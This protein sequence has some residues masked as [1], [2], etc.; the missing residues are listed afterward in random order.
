ME[1]RLKKVRVGSGFYVDAICTLAIAALAFCAALFVSH[2]NA[3]A[4]TDGWEQWGTCEWQIDDEGTLTIRSVDN[5]GEGE[6]GNLDDGSAAPWNA[7]ASE[8]KTVDISSYVSAGDSLQGLFEG[9]SNLTEIKGL[10]NLD[11]SSV[12]NMSGL[13]SGCSS[14]EAIDLS[15][16]DATYVTDMSSMFA[17]CSNLESIDLSLFN[18]DSLY[19]ASNMFANCTNLTSIDLSVFPTYNIKDFSGMFR[20]CSSLS[21]IIV[22]DFDFVGENCETMAGMFEGCTSLTHLPD[23]FSL[24]YN[25]NNIDTTGMFLNTG[26]ETLDTFYAGNNEDVIN[27]DWSGDNR[28]FYA[29]TPGWNRWGNAEWVIDESGCL[30]I[31][32]R[33]NAESGDLE[34]ADYSQP[35]AS[36]RSQIRSVSITKPIRVYSHISY[37]FQGCSNL[38]TVEGLK[39]F[40][41]IE[42]LNGLFANCSSLKS[43]A[44]NE[45][46][47]SSLTGL[48]SMFSGC[49]SLESIDLSNMDLSEAT[50]MMSVFDG[51]T[52]LK[53]VNLTGINTQNATDMS[54]M[55]NDCQSLASIDLTDFDTQSVVN[56]QGMFYNCSSLKELD[57][58]SLNLSNTTDLSSLVSD[59]TSLE[60]ITLPEGTIYAGDLTSMF[61]NCEALTELNMSDTY[62]KNIEN[63]PSMFSGCTGLKT[64]DL[65]NFDT[66]RAIDMSHMFTDCSSLASLAIPDNFIGDKCQSIDGMFSGCVSLQNLPDNFSFGPNAEKLTANGGIFY[67]NQPLTRAV[68]LLVTYYNGSDETVLNYNWEGDNRR[69]VTPAGDIAGTVTIS[70]NPC[71]GVALKATV[72][73][74]DSC[75]DAQLLYQ[76]FDAADGS[77]VSDPTDSA[78]FAIPQ[79][80]EGKSFYCVVTDGSGTYGS[81]LKSDAITASHTFGKWVITTEPTCVDEGEETRTC[82]KCGATETRTIP[83]KGHSPI[84]AWSSD[85]SG[86]W[87]ACANCDEH[88]DAAEH[89]FGEWAEKDAATCTEGGTEARTC[90]TCGYEETRSTDPAGHS[91][92]EWSVTTPA[93]CTAEGV[94]SRTC[95]KCGAT[96]TRAIDATGHTFGEWVTTTEPTCTEE[97]EETRTCENCDAFET[98]PVAAK[99]HTAGEAWESNATDHW[100][101]CTE[102][103]VELDSEAHKFGEWTTTVEPTEDV[104]GEREHTCEVCGHVETAEVPATGH[105]ADGA[106]HSDESG[107]WHVCTGCGEEIEKSAHEYGEWTTTLEPTCTEEGTKTRACTVCGYEQTETISENGHS[108][109]E[110]E[111]T[112]EPTCVDE[113]E[114]TRTCANCDAT[115][116]RPVP[117]TGEHVY[118]GWTSDESGHRHICETCGLVTDDAAHDFGEWVVTKDVTC[119]EDGVETRTCATCGYEETR[120]V[121]APGHEPATEWSSDASEHWHACAN[122]DEHL[123]A[124]AHEFGAWT[125]TTE[126][127]CTE[128]GSQTRTCA[129]CDYTEAAVIPAAGHS[130][131]DWEIISD[132]TET[133]DGSKKHVCEAC[134]FE[135]TVTIPATGGQQ[136]S[137]DDN[138][139]DSDQQ[140]G[141]TDDAQNG[142]GNASDAST[143]DDKGNALAQ[144]GD[145]TPVA[146]LAFGI[147]ATLAVA[148][149]A[150]RKLRA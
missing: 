134:G 126:A 100:H 32:P 96:E 48:T 148:G 127:T 78:E 16:L 142:N 43:V 109:G 115:E 122:C 102:C 54:Y 37:L 25:A 111:V 39:N 138:K 120:P 143:N 124:A 46:D 52:S 77:A 73:L 38:E 8:V 49:S 107:H 57:F 68:N 139:G 41:N 131:G 45:I 27:Y 105:T 128:D 21:S 9:C 29:A 75:A 110:W 118:A 85:E 20:G 108:F 106:W 70:G 99:G 67:V 44:I 132:A 80:S 90:A 22:S 133:Q 116:T 11:T 150:M 69:L 135:E 137:Q 1:Q 34:N 136:G 3:Y 42:S 10:G 2:Q 7:R 55:F 84:D 51:C 50:W 141:Q 121:A 60:K 94:E 129:T 17:S 24:G 83:A 145:S 33:F 87:H 114:E 146:P 58:S 47:T 26:S 66:S 12:T 81:S 62:F 35:W 125:V 14:L 15:E 104:A 59:C 36:Q 88:L 91:F 72:S 130:F 92:G 40:K 31:R 64:I 30:T 5:E 112:T 56:A 95:E 23:N 97:G 4:A 79:S 101:A 82:E 113:G 149:I 71:A 147:L 18:P 6:L 117:A 63:M 140:G 61:S 103:G 74:D 19:N 93:T 98:H 53:E 123:D 119:T 76:W 144:T 65:S 13:F 89:E 86:H 28:H